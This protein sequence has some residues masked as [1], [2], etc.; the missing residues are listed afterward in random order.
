V[1]DAD[2]AIRSR[3]M[4]DGFLEA[5][6]LIRTWSLR[7]SVLDEAVSGPTPPE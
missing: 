7:V 6:S 1:E 2:H 3:L 4:G 5:N